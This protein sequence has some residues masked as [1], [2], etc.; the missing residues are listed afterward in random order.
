MNIALKQTSVEEEDEKR[1]GRP[2]SEAWVHGWTTMVRWAATTPVLE[3]PKRS[4]SMPP[5]W[6]STTTLPPPD[7]STVT[8]PVAAPS[9]LTC[10]AA[11]MSV[12]SAAVHVCFCFLFCL[13]L[14][15]RVLKFSH[16]VFVFNFKISKF[17]VCSSLCF[18]FGFVFR[19]I[20]KFAFAG[21]FG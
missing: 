9:T 19:F 6:A 3:A 17:R 13:F 7:S 16:F 21:R 11:L 12:W 18:V 14:V 10:A 2:S 4:L 1:E 20:S 5:C 15:L 8:W